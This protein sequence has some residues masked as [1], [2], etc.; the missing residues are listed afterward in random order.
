VAG[1]EVRLEVF[2][3]PIDLLLHLITRQRVDIYDV[4]LSTITD[5]YLSVLG[6]MEDMDLEQATGFLVIAATL[7]EL[8]SIRLLPA[9][10]DLDDEDR[11]LLEERDLL[12][13]KLVECATFREA[14]TALNIALQRGSSFFPRSVPLE[15]PYASLQP[16]VELRVTVAQ[17]TRAAARVFAPAPVQL[18]LDMTHVSPIR[19]SV[20]DAIEIMVGRLKVQGS[21]TFEELCGGSLER[22][23][24]VVR[25]LGLL[26]L[27]K[28]G[29]VELSQDDRF[30]AIQA[31]W[32]GEADTEE[33]LADVEEYSGESEVTA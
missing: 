16:T 22:I 26:E 27:F 8:K 23:E 21:C 17:L 3:G 4:S 19:A 9:P 10:H 15:E 29:A 20:K 31:S 12:L 1:H 7:L 6:S 2:Q 5:E 25:F 11:A 33:V 14:G 30:G 32:T 28:A 24:V 18:Q 13:A